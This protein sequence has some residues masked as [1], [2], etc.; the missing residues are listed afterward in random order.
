MEKL[1][2][3]ARARYAFAEFLGGL[4]KRCTPE[5]LLILDMAM[6]QR[7]AFTALG[8]LE[9]C[10]SNPGIKVSRAT[11]FNTLPLLIQCGL[12][13]K[14]A[15][16]GDVTYEAIRSTGQ[17]RARQN[18]IC[19]VCG[20]IHHLDAPSLSAWVESQNFRGFTG[21]PETAVVYVYGECSR[22]RRK[23]LSARKNQ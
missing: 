8:L 11:L 22:C 7:K 14:N 21:V 5:R 16:D 6:E 17:L 18:L 19:T 20:K 12:V 10:L 3:K 2:A 15:C 1:Q 4:G 13:R 9:K 23:Q